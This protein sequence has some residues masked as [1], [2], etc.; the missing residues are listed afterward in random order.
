MT[1]PDE[2][3]QAA[4]DGFPFETAPNELHGR[5]PIEV[6][7]T[8]FLDKLNRG[9]SPSMDE[10]ALNHPELADQILELFP[11]ISAMEQL[12]QE[13]ES[14]RVRHRI[15]DNFHVER[16]GDCRVIR[17]IGRGGM[18]IV[19]EG[20][21]QKPV[22]RVAIKLLP[23]HVANVPNARDR[24]QREARTLAKLNHPNIVPLD[25]YGEYEEFHFYVMPLIRGVSLDWIINQLGKTD[26][27]VYA[28]EIARKMDARKPS[29]D[30]ILT[31][32]K[33]TNRPKWPHQHRSLRRGDWRK[34]AMIGLQAANAL[35]YAHARRV[36]HNDIKPGNLLLD[37]DG[38]LWVTDFGL[39][40]SFD[41]QT[42][43]AEERFSGTL[44]YMPPERF[45]GPG[46]VRSD[47]YSLGMTLYELCTLTPA[48]SSNSPEKM[49]TRIMD[50]EPIRPS[51]LNAEIP[52]ELESI[53]LMAIAKNPVRRYQ[54][55]GD[56]ASDL[57]R[58]L[59]GKPIRA[60]K[61]NWL[62]RCVDWFRR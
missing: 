11:V 23:F 43:D 6:L 41:E 25:N 27:V 26:G 36:V 29:E 17:E 58:F 12:K 49:I 31:D 44:R 2:E 55:V 39:A 30:R 56:M 51:E 9:E 37:A 10:Y 45:S 33:S 57:L 18:G 20:E 7:A 52:G 32:A 4:L 21:Q 34:F 62:I 47:V 19:F 48:F 5:E 16:L 28:E 8:E 38:R 22:R 61:R 60:G 54:S 14:A 3:F 35:R 53:I 1:E 40:K 42:D 50:S 15:P 59:N 46:T 13:K 24:F